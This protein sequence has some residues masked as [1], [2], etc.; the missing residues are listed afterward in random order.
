MSFETIQGNLDSIDR[1]L[2][3]S[4]CPKQ[5]DGFFFRL[6]G[7]DCFPQKVSEAL[8]IRAKLLGC[9]GWGAWIVIL[10]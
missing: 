2:T 5:L 1:R 6:G 3:Q 4:N 7:E 8:I 10:N 9:F